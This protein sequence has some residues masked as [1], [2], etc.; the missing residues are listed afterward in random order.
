MAAD[1]PKPLM[2]PK[3][4]PASQQEP[5]ASGQVNE[6]PLPHPNEEVITI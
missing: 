1:K 6:P 3:S 5:K 4:C 2:E